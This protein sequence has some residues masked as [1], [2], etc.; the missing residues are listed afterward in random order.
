MVHS[1][2]L[3]CRVKK[4]TEKK[5]QENLNSVKEFKYFTHLMQQKIV[6]EHTPNLK[7]FLFLGLGYE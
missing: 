2:K 7:Q 3:L 4:K 6:E 5:N 1:S